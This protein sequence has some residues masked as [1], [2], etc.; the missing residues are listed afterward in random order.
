MIKYEGVTFVKA[1]IEKMT[2]T[3]FID[4]H[5]NLFWRDRDEKTRRKM[6]TSVYGKIVKPAKTKIS[7]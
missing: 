3:E 6:L 7:D 1:E 5:L 4:R 2:K